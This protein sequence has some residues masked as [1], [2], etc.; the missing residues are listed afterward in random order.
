LNPHPVIVF[1]GMCLLCTG[2]A[3]FV[4][5]HDRRRIFRFATA[6]SPFGRQCYASHGLDPDAM[7]TMLVI[8]D[9]RILTESDAVIAILLA[10][11]WPWRLAGILRAVPRYIRDNVYR[12]IAR[13]RYRWLGRRAMC[14][15]PTD[16]VA[17]RLV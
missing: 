2:S 1:D 14:W 11:G 10:L 17:D 4:L 3:Q 8:V 12:W 16:D 9:G 7:A 6:Q 5:K 15:C 13:N